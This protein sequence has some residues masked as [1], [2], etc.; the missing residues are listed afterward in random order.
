MYGP[1]EIK[2][3]APTLKR[4]Q[5]AYIDRQLAA[6]AEGMRQNDIDL[7]IRTIAS[8][9]TPREMRSVAEFYGIPTVRAQ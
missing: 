1:N 7:P 6:F 8:Q 4:Q 3:G 9:L 5:S 2:F